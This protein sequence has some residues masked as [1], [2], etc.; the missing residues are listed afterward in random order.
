MDN[1]DIYN[2]LAEIKERAARTEEKID[3][4]TENTKKLDRVN[5]IANSADRKA[6]LAN[7]RIDKIDKWMFAIGSASALAIIGALINLV[8]I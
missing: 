8:I 4:L 5:D 2:T 1:K 3:N 7:H 6:D